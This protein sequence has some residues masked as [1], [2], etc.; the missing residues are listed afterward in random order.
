MMPDDAQNGRKGRLLSGRG[1]IHIYTGDGKGK[2]TAAF[3]LAMRCRGC[4]GRICIVQFLKTAPTGEVAFAEALHD[5]AW[6]I[7]RFESSH[8]FFFQ[9]DDA[10][11]KKL[12]CEIESAL[13]FIEQRA[14][15]GDCDM[16]VIDEILG[17]IENGL[18]DE[19]R[20]VS[21]LESR[22]DGVE[23]VLTGRNAPAS[24]VDVADYVT[25][26]KPIKHPYEKGTLARRGI[27]Y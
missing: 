9:M 11:K 19:R 8:E 17:A 3:G 6:Q 27:E 23:I 18:L 24:L 14:M 22:A 5:P 13:T 21:I 26:L 25:E 12:K 2:T 15:A 7:Y 4:G 1:L 20:L 16:L 10:Q